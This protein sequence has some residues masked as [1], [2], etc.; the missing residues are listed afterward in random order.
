M[1]Q[2]PLDRPEVSGRFEWMREDILAV[3]G[4]SFF[5][6]TPK[7]VIFRD[8]PMIWFERDEQR[9]GYIA[10]CEE[11]PTVAGFGKTL[12]QTRS[13]ARTEIKLA[14]LPWFGWNVVL[15]VLT[16]LRLRRGPWPY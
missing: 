4:G 1:K 5:Y 7:M 16:V 15:K 12:R 8:E 11:L 3:V 6:E 2:V 13:D 14:L 10:T 9:G